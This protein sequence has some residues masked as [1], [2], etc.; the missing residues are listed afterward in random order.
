MLR[1][2]AAAG[3]GTRSQSVNN[4][5]IIGAG[6]W[7]TAFADGFYGWLGEL[8]LVGRPLPSSQWLTAS[9]S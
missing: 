4:P 3:T 6:W 8:R 5:W 7:D 2:V 1:N 9:L